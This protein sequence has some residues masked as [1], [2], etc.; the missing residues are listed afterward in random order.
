M[1]FTAVILAGGKSSRMGRDKAF[2]QFQG[3][4]LIEHALQVVRDA[5]A[6]EVLISGRPEQD[7]SALSCPVLLD[8]T[9]DCGPLGGIEQALS[10]ASHPLVLVLAVDLPQMTPAFLQC[11]YGEIGDTVERVPTTGSALGA[12]PVLSGRPEPLAAFYPKK[13][14]PTAR[15]MLA[16]RQLAARDFAEACFQQGLARMI[17]VP[18]CYEGCFTNWNAPQDLEG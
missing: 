12:V 1:T 18:A 13:A 9:P 14:H 3:K 7:F 17:S 11:L 4:P 15:R 6:G 16:E 5:G 10:A 2:L 8:V